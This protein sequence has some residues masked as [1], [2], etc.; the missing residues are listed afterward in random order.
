MHRKNS[1]DAISIRY[2]INGFENIH[3]IDGGFES[4]TPQLAKHLKSNYK[5]DIIHRAVVTHPDKDHAEGLAGILEEFSVGELW[6][7]MPWD[8]VDELLPH[9]ARY[10]DLRQLKQRL[11]DDYPY[12]AELEKIAV[13]KGIPIY[14]P[15]QGTK[16]GEFTVLAPSRERYLQLIIDSEKTPQRSIRSKGLFSPFGEAVRALVPM[17]QAGWGQEKFST[18]PT[19]VENEMSVIQ[20]ANICGRRIL[21]TGDAGIQGMT[22][23]ANYLE[24]RG[25]PLPGI[26]HFQVPHHG[27]RRNLST[28]ILDRWL[29]PRIPMILKEGEERFT[30]MIS[31][32]KDDPDHPKKAVVRALYHRGARIVTTETGAFRSHYNA[33][34]RHGWKAATRPDYPNEQED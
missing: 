10:N 13:R 15:F 1:G 5:T 29:G 27:G 25:V 12:I 18:E 28:E 9:F 8:Y 30:A 22:E 24:R 17:I 6:M 20:F 11:R 7:L 33:P 31:S 14:A 2:Q 32:A 23:A 19:S 21:L 4:T 3:V 16:I 34:D 26:K